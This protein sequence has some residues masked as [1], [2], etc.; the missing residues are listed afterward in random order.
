MIPL[1]TFIAI[2]FNVDNI[3]I[4]FIPSFFSLAETI[5]V[6]SKDLNSDALSL[7]SFSKSTSYFCISC[8]HV[9]ISS[10]GTSFFPAY[11]GLNYLY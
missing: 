2:S 7:N 8:K 11:F 1:P 3:C 4:N 10:Y 9:K 6:S 5:A